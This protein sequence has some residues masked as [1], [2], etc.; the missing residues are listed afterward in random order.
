M[1]GATA[2]SAAHNSHQ[3]GIAGRLKATA[4]A[5]EQDDHIRYGSAQWIV[6]QSKQF[7]QQRQQHKHQ[8]QAIQSIRY[9]P[10]DEQQQQ[11]Q[12]ASDDHFVVMRSQLQA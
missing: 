9:G 1:T 5:S 12:R 4:G 2:D 3:V 7:I 6:G 8:L 11:Q 10:S